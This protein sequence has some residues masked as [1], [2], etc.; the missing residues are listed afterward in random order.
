M[1]KQIAIT[2]DYIVVRFENNSIDVYNRYGN[3]KEAL[4][5]IAK[6]NHFEYNPD[7]NTRQFGK[8]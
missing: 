5:E 7:W 1:I 6:E 2:E 4:R 8:N 3:A